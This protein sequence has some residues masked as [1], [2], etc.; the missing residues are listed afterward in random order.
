MRTLTITVAIHVEPDAI[1][2]YASNP[3]HLPEWAP[4]FA[5]SVTADGDEWLVQM[6]DGQVRMWFTPPNADG[7]LDHIV[8]MPDGED[9]MNTMR[10]TAQGAGSE[11]SFLLHQRAGMSEA[12]FAEDTALVQADLQRLKD[13]LE[14]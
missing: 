5:R 1:M 4:G 14:D 6:A 11:V 2:A 8:R 9:V 3:L 13:I 10:V 12:Q 7:I